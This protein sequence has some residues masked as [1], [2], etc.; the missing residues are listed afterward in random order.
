MTPRCGPG[1]ELLS[2]PTHRRA[3]VRYNPIID[4]QLRWPDWT[5]ALTFIRSGT[6]YID[7]ERMVFYLDIRE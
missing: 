3:N 1:E 4:A 2:V 5:F 6:E 7:L